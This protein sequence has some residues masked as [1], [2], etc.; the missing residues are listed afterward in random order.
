MNITDKA[1]IIT[2]F[3]V[4]MIFST[5]ILIKVEPKIITKE[6]KQDCPIQESHSET[7][8]ILDRNALKELPFCPLT[9]EKTG[10]CYDWYGKNGIAITKIEDFNNY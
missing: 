2:F 9:Y 5:A 10:Y 7:V 1:M 8:Y 6:V 3:I 4:G